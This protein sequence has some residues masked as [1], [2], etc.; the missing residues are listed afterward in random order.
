MK[1]KKRYWLVV[2]GGVFAFLGCEKVIDIPLNEAEQ[3]L[4]VEAVLKD[5]PGN[6]YILITKSGSVYEESEFEAVP[7]AIV[8]VTDQDGNEFPFLYQGEALYHSPTF[9]TEPNKN[10]YL[11][12]NAFDR[13]ITATSKTLS[14]PKLDSLT[15][16][17][18]TGSFGVPVGDTLYLVSFHSVDEIAEKNYYLLK[19]FRN[20]NA[21]AGYYLGNDD[22]I[23]GAYYQAQFFGAEADPKDT[24]KV[25]MISMDQKNYDYYVGLS[26]NLSN[27]VFSAAPA[28]PPSNLVGNALGFFGAYTTDTLEILIP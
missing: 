19:I 3:T 21:N 27:S 20:G 11:K 22:F 23:N 15:H 14:K 10:Y 8:T 13:E 18:I 17:A 7:D 26:N 6:N 12:V 25:E 2:L 24:V 28:N 5:S 1:N 9:F 16:T 4:V